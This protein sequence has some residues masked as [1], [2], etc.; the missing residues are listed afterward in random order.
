MNDRE[1]AEPDDS[2]GQVAPNEQSDPYEPAEPVVDDGLH[3]RSLLAEDPDDIAVF[4]VD[5]DAEL[6]QRVHQL[7]VVQVVELGWARALSL[8]PEERFRDTIEAKIELGLTVVQA[9]REN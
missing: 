6:A 5:L 3:R 4:A 9:Q 2:P 8:E 7:V 1:P